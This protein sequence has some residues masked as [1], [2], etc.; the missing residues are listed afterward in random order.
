ML[1]D[2]SARVPSKMAFQRHHGVELSLS[3]SKKQLI[4]LLNLTSF[5]VFVTIYGGGERAPSLSGL[6]R[7]P[8]HIDLW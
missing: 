1:G 4:F 3:R 7:Y 6:V 8:V 2:E 5:C